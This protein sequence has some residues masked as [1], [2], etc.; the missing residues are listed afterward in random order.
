MKILEEMQH[1][2]VALERAALSKIMTDGY[3]DPWIRAEYFSGD[4][5]RIFLDLSEMWR[6]NG[7]IDLNALRGPL[8]PIGI[9]IMESVGS[10]TNTGKKLLI[11][12]FLR[13][14]TAKEV[15][16]LYS[17]GE[18]LENVPREIQAAVSNL[19]INQEQKKYNHA[20]S[21]STVIG[22]IQAGCDNNAILGVPIGIDGFDSIVHG[23]EKKKFY[24]L[25]ALKKTG[26]SR[27]MVYVALRLAES[28][29]RVLMNSLE[30]SDVQLNL[31]AFSRLSGV[32]SS[33]L[34]N[35]PLPVAVLPRIATAQEDRKSVV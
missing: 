8:K 3:I 31:L 30:M 33:T 2:E 5:K 32:D 15:I 13:R 1:R 12:A 28:G 4:E 11:D 10:I 17:R 6:M 14:E 19:L 35:L 34:G 27:F 25:G 21:L 18:S 26:K 9:E 29:A 20:E 24:V 16:A 23:F 22:L 7:D